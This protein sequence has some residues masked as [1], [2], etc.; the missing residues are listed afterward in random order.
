MTLTR[1]LYCLCISCCLAPVYAD[2]Q[3]VVIDD[4]AFIAGFWQGTGFGGATEEMWMPP[5]QGRMFGIFKQSRDGAL[6]FSEFMEITETSE[7]WVLRLKHFNP[8]FSGWEAQDK[9]VT[10][11]L[12]TL[13]ENKAVFQGLS[14]ELIGPDKLRI[15]LQM[16][17]GSRG[18]STSAFELVR[19]AL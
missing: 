7:G 11:P 4:F 18:A 8:D 16:N 9:H 6:Q 17:E 12:Q 2:D 3:D 1:Q 10:F 5:S 13:S 19:Q 15:E 14:Y